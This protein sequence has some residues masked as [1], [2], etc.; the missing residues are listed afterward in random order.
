MQLE[1]ALKNFELLNINHVHNIEN[2]ATSSKCNPSQQSKKTNSFA[3]FRTNFKINNLEKNCTSLENS[4]W[5]NSRNY[6]GIFI[7]WLG[8]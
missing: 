8:I 2:H 1:F 3:A 7:H 6:L 5:A 4:Y